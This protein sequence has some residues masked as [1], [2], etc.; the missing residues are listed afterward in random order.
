M[1]RVGA[2]SRSFRGVEV[3][4]WGSEKPSRLNATEVPFNVPGGVA[5]GLPQYIVNTR[6]FLRKMEKRKDAL[7]PDMDATVS[8]KRVE[9][10]GGYTGT[11]EFEGVS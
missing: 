5:G 4:L 10:P 1:L 9:R 6:T 7:T 11:I 2:G 3:V 8:V